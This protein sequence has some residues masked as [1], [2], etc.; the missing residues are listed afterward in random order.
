MINVN[1]G[2]FRVAVRQF[3]LLESAIRKQW[4]TYEQHAKTGLRLEI[5]VLNLRS[6]YESLFLSRQLKRG[7]YD[8]AFPCTEWLA[9]ASKSGILVNLS[10]YREASPPEGSRMPGAV[11]F[12]S[13][14][15]LVTV[16]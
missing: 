13:S 12:L 2:A 9:E 5:A 7:S 14:N 8:V 15:N 10:P 6:L 1:R 4:E 11:H 3:T 16:C